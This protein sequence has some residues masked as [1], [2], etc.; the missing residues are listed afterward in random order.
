MLHLA[1][2]LEVLQVEAHLSFLHLLGRGEKPFLAEAPGRDEGEE[3][4][5]MPAERIHQLA[6]LPFQ[7]RA[8]RVAGIQVGMKGLR[9]FDLMEESGLN[10]G[11]E[12]P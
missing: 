7:P 5:D 6:Q 2:E 3:V 4:G 9:R 11:V 12:N 8:V 1:L 10:L